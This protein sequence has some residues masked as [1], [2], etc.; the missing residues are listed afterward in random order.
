M[1]THRHTLTVAFLLSLSHTWDETVQRLHGQPGAVDRPRGHNQS[2]FD[3]L[4][5]PNSNLAATRTPV[6]MTTAA[7]Q[8]LAMPSQEIKSL[9]QLC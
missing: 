7:R 3:T 4:Q 2:V 9:K 8:H 1:N 5:A 6:P